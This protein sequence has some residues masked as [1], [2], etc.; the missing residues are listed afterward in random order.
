[1]PR[2]RPPSI[3]FYYDDFLSGVVDMD[4]YEVGM[5]I[6]NLCFQWGHNFVPTD[7]QKLLKITGATP[8]KFAKHWPSVREKFVEKDENQL[9]NERAQDAMEHKLALSRKRSEAGRKGGRP[10]SKS[11]SKS[12]RVSKRKAKGSRKL[13]AGSKEKQEKLSADFERFWTA[14]PRGRRK[15]K[16]IAFTAFSKAI[17][18]GASAETLIRRAGEY[19]RSEEGQGEYVKMPSTWLN[20]TCWEDDD[21]AWNRRA[22]QR[23]N[24]GSGSITAL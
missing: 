3:D 16:A 13:E 18:L 15:S 4:P 23:A 20:Q 21:Y 1:M 22:K 6:R 11:K 7:A 24:G 12:K 14:F 17:A 8:E 10:K 19:A 5:Y 9:V 2:K